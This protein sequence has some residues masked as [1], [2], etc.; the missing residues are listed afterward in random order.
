MKRCLRYNTINWQGLLRYVTLGKL[1]P[2][3]EKAGKLCVIEL[4]VNQLAATAACTL[5][6]GAPVF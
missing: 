3:L 6:S 5:T 2:K 1:T 4:F